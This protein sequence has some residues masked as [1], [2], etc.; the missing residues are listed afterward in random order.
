MRKTLVHKA[1][2]NVPFVALGREREPVSLVGFRKCLPFLFKGLI[3]LG[4]N[5][6]T[7]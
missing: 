2:H 6:L 3:S 5:A 7:L 1:A 4:D